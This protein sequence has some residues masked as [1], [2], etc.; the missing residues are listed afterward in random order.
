MCIA[1]NTNF[2]QKKP[3]PMTP[4]QIQQQ[5]KGKEKQQA[6]AKKD[7]NNKPDDIFQ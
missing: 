2:D 6:L 7:K 1:C 5:Q 3:H 4:D